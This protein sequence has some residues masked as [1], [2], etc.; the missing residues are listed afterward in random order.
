MK[1]HE[2]TLDHCRQVLGQLNAYVDQELALELCQELESHLDGCADCQV[3]LDSLTK[4]IHLYQGLREAT[5]PLPADL[6]S[7]LIQQIQGHIT[8][9]TS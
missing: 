4:T 5:L 1:V 2:R 3:V 6:E 7:R 9:H 8:P